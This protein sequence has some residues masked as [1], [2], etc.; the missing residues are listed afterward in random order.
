[1]P[2]V[3]RMSPVASIEMPG[4]NMSWL[5]FVTVIALTVSVAGSNVAV[6][7]CATLPVNDVRLCADHVKTCERSA[8]CHFFVHCIHLA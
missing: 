4:Q 1:L 8:F 5:V 3:T 2:P 6:S 7:V